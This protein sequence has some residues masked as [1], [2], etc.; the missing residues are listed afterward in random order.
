MIWGGFQHRWYAGQSSSKCTL[1]TY[2]F[3]ASAG[4]TN[5]TELRNKG[6]G[7]VWLARVLCGPQPQVVSLREGGSL[8]RPSS[9]CLLPPNP[10]GAEHLAHPGMRQPW[11]QTG[12]WVK[13]AD[14]CLYSRRGLKMCGS[15]AW[16]SVSGWV[17]P[18]QGWRAGRQ[19]DL[20]KG[21]GASH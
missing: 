7:S 14:P 19:P 21:A 15:W 11:D 1:K 13:P 4:K 8:S 6:L 16:K 18:E 17:T 9:I 10:E 2:A 20:E 12:Q 5:F 3:C